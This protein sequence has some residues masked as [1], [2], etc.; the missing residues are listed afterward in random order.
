LH[1]VIPTLLNRAE[2][3]EEKTRNG[4][5]QNAVWFQPASECLANGGDKKKNK[6]KNKNKKEELE[7]RKS[8]ITKRTNVHCNYRNAY[9]WLS[10]REYTK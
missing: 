5:M 4:N 2:L 10:P 8:S 7:N 6:I 3:V 1:N 9:S